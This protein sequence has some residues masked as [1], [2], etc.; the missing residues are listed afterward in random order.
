MEDA[1][2][3]TADRTRTTIVV[4]LR[5][6]QHHE[7]GPMSAHIQSALHHHLVLPT[8]VLVVTVTAAIALAAAVLI[9][10]SSDQ[11]ASPAGAS[12]GTPPAQHGVVCVD[13]RTVGHC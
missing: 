6:S 7:E 10:G 9:A 8:W 5:R 12:A 1:R 11:I 2:P 13:S 3:A 4:A